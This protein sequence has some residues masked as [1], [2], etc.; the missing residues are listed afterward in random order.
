MFR[1]LVELSAEYE[2][3]WAVHMWNGRMDI[4]LG[5]ADLSGTRLPCLLL[6]HTENNADYAYD[7]YSLSSLTPGTKVVQCLHLDS[8][9]RSSHSRYLPAIKYLP[10][11]DAMPINSPIEVSS[12][13]EPQYS[14]DFSTYLSSAMD[15][16][17]SKLS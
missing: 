16:A 8:N 9:T 3:L 6:S 15:T 4:M 13:S 1:D 11:R 10:G 2:P 17:K 12:M 7:F 14:C 5:V